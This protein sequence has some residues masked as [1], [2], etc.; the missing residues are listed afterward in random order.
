MQKDVVMAKYIFTNGNIITMDNSVPFAEAIA[1]NDGYISGAGSI[2]DIKSAFPH[3]EIYDLK[4]NTLLPGFID[5]HSHFPSGGMNRLFGVDLSVSNMNELIDRLSQKGSEDRPNEWI[6]G[7]SFDDQFMDDKSFPTI[8]EL[9][10][11]STKYPIFMRHVSGHTGYVNSRALAIAGINR[12]SLDPTG[13]KIG[14]DAD[15]NPNGV[16]EGIP[17]QTLVRR[18]IPPYSR[19]EMKQALLDE[20]RVYASVGITTAQGGPAFS[21]MD[22]EMGYAVTELFLECA[23]D[24]S[25]PLRTVLFVRANKIENLK[26]YINC[27]AGTDLSG[28]GMVTL[29]AAKLWADGDPRTHTGYFSSPY[30]LRRENEG[31]FFGEYLYTPQ[32]LTELILPM[33]R[34]GWQIAIHAN[35]D[36]G[37]E[38][39]LTAFEN[40]QHIFPRPDARHLI[41]HSQYATQKQLMRM[42]MAGV[43]PCFFTAPL[44]YWDHIHELEVGK[45]RVENFCPLGDAAHI[46]LRFNLHTD[47]PI[48]PVDPLVQVCLAVTRK[49]RVKTI[50][51]R[52]QSIS[53]WRALK[54]VTIDA[55]YLNFEEN[56]KGSIRP[57]KYA[58]F[59][60]L[61]QNPLSVPADEIKNIKVLTTIV[62][63]KVIYNAK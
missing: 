47:S 21:P 28:C 33:H 17:A 20:S 10:R 40:L 12:N 51:G 57:G 36:A 32:S 30:K 55:A 56:L 25:L 60:I 53:A 49:S 18:L 7:H 42:L 45:E 54:A 8:H 34:R 27:Q 62:G 22:A 29:G 46:G 61:D 35:G 23:Q 39:V 43:Y 6:I 59:V 58:D 38:T 11:A 14:R 2:N 3:A 48:L 44:Y 19:N 26:P 5:G 15:G 50:W 24:G 16:L 9:D 13:G 41:I 1:V 37:I 63:G 31:D 52:H 4:G